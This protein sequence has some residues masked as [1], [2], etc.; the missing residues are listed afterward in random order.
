LL[1]CWAA[2]VVTEGFGVPAPGQTVLVAAGVV[3]GTGRLNLALV[4]LLGWLAA[5]LGDN[6]GFAIG[7]F[8]GR[9]LVLR[10]GR[11]VTLTEARLKKA[12]HLFDRHGGKIVAVAR[13]IDGLRQANGIIA[14]LVGLS[15]RRFLAFNAIGAA[16]WAGVWTTAGYLA[17]DHLARLHAQFHRYE[18]YLLIAIG[19]FLLALTAYQLIHRRKP[20]T[21]TRHTGA[22]SL[23][24]ID[25]RSLE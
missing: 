6:L 17:G 15:W 16:V 9:G 2:I 10:F 12:E 23:I 22:F 20:H 25:P 19:I 8:G 3:A 21:E 11:Y 1:L 24:K 18:H 13:F 5:I 7:H 4:I 14:G